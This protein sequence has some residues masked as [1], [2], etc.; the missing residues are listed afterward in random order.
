MY[1]Q[2][3]E[4]ELVKRIQT[5]RKYRMVGLPEE[6]ILDIYR[7][8]SCRTTHPTEALERTKTKL[9]NITALYL[10]NLDYDEAKKDLDKAYAEGG[11]E[12]IE[13]VCTDILTRHRST[14]ERM[15]YYPA[16]FRVIQEVCDG[17]S[18][19]LDLA[20]GLNPFALP[21]MALSAEI[22]Y[23]AY[24]IHTPRVELINHFFT[25]S[26][27]PPLAEVRDVLVRP[28]QVE[29]DAA[30]LLKEAHRME[31]RR[32]GAV[33]EIAL[34]LNARVIFISLPNRSMDSR[35]DL[36]EHMRA[37]VEEGICSSD[38]SVFGCREFPGETLFW[39]R[40]VHG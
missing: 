29:A 17:V 30:I 37:L 16:F 7:R 18:T 10:E 2:P 3:D 34:A 40:R 15:P 38:L 25:L 22:C 23:Y 32:A 5:S 20:C 26:G 8:E 28:P 4:L 33:R 27:R 12:A 19:L 6:T 14:C 21:M 36:R 35:R 31:K 13:Q 39:L 9:H 11:E 1:P 24:D